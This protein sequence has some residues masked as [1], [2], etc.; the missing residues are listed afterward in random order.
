[1]DIFYEHESDGLYTRH[2]RE[3][4]AD[5]SGYTMHIHDRCEI[6]YFVDGE[7]DYLV[8]GTVYHM[9]RGSL[10]VMRPGE[11]HM[12]KLLTNGVYERYAV[13][14]P[15]S[16]LDAIDSE[17][18]L[19]RLY[20]ERPLGERNLYERPEY[21]GLLG[22]LCGK[23]ED[24][25]ER[26]ITAYRILMEILSGLDEEF[27]QNSSETKKKKTRDSSL[28]EKI[29]RYVN[30]HIY[31]GLSVPFLAEKF[32]VS[33]SQIGRLFKK[34]TGASCWEYITAKR[35]I[36]ARE[37]IED[38]ESAG[39][40]AEKCGFGDYSSFYRAYVKRHGESPRKVL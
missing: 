1:M 33:E 13:N 32:Y 14:F 20:T 15:L 2:V 25:Y 29:L 4:N 39:A 30:E 31:E 36:A 40:A 35:L 27:R 38:G 21:E 11:V 6:Y 7:A 19:I 5:G 17:R 18:R 9:R 8:E 24:E 26:R 3:E 23:H 37:M 12:A 34:S 16:F 28:S 22:T 10:L